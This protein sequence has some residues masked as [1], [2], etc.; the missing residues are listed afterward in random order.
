M[1][2][3]NRELDVTLN[4]LRARGCHVGREW[5]HECINF[6]R[7]ENN[8]YTPKALEN[9]VFEQW[10]LGDLSD[11]AGTGSLPPN[12]SDTLKITLQGKMACQIQ[13][14]TDIGHSCY[15]QMQRVRNEDVGN[16]Q[17][18]ETGKEFQQ[19][20][21]PR[22]NRMLQLCLF[23]G[24]QTVKAIEYK[25][26]P[27]LKTDLIP[28]T[29]ILLQ[30]PVVC[31]RGIIM[32]EDK[33]VTLLG[34]EVDALVVT[35]AYENVLARKL[36]L[37]ENPDPYNL[38]PV[39]NALPQA[40]TLN[41]SQEHA[42][43]PLPPQQRIHQPVPAP[44]QPRT[45]NQRHEPRPS[46]TS[47]VREQ[48]NRKMTQS[49]L[50][51]SKPAQPTTKAPP[52]EQPVEFC[53]SD[54]DFLNIPLNDID[55][56]TEME[57]ENGS[58][59]N[60]THSRNGSIKTEHKTSELEMGSDEEAALLA[61][62][63]S[64]AMNTD[65]FMDQKSVKDTLHCTA[66][67]STGESSSFKRPAS[68]VLPDESLKKPL[69]SKRRKETSS[70]EVSSTTPSQPPTSHLNFLLSDD[71]LDFEETSSE[72]LI[73]LENSIPRALSSHPFVYLSQITGGVK[74]ASKTY[75]IKAAVITVIEKLSISQGEWKLS[76]KITD[77]SANVD[78]RF[79]STVLDELIGMSAQAMTEMRKQIPTHPEKKE[80]VRKTL[81]Q[82]QGRLINLNCL[83]DLEIGKD[84][85]PLVV[86][87]ENISR[88]T[89]AGLKSRQCQVKSS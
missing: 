50:S 86:G 69:F 3:A 29:K 77:G 63:A 24:A 2:N 62:E 88:K 31:R 18:D 53:G 4:A 16:L 87:L 27:L 25:P 8:Q 45:T 42:Q 5:L 39:G 51:W 1:A 79:S 68:S 73:K 46:V 75:R 52:Q 64:L 22:S 14:V 20:W 60:S 21:E 35:N 10:T 71:F 6:F 11:V 32:L 13:F 38:T 19:A 36:N 37:P 70:Q 81:E 43:Q 47:A 65:V 41:P 57:Y 83:L 49:T 84:N 7:S 82:A 40:Q 9:F 67:R 30:G 44:Q 85:L 61:A 58:H 54:E 59:P 74:E 23:D 28:G 55:W 56:G 48:P 17:V 80:I 89:V 33:H 26:I 15:T 76:A 12:L 34:G 72:P 66:K 78:V